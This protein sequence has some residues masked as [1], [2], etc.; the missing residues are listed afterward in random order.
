M[1][2]KTPEA[3]FHPFKNPILKYGLLF[4]FLLALG[5]GTFYKFFGIFY[6]QELHGPLEW[7][8]ISAGLASLFGALAGFWFGDLADR[9][10]PLL[11]IIYGWAGY[12]VVFLGLFL[13]RDPIT[14]VIY[15]ALPIYVEFIGM[16]KIIAEIT[17]AA[18]RNRGIATSTIARNVGSAIGVILGG[19]L[20]FWL[21]LPDILVVTL[22]LFA[23]SLV[24]LLLTIRVYRSGKSH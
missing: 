5:I 15:W 18:T 24:F 14:A 23:P 6:V 3:S 1:T 10:S 13:Q 2:E 21:S 19:I 11:V 22:V 17:P 7:V 12:L 16:N 4:D 9:K 8:G 20:S